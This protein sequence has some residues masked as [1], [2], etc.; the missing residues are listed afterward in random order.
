MS[1]FVQST[2]LQVTNLYYY[3]CVLFGFKCY[4]VGTAYFIQCTVCCVV[5]SGGIQHAMCR[6]VWLCNSG[7]TCA[8]NRPVPSVHLE[9]YVLKGRPGCVA[10]LY[11]IV[12]FIYL[13]TYTDIRHTERALLATNSG[14][15][16]LQE[17]NF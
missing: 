6:N 2:L 12:S 15:C 16:N 13:T 9:V 7:A 5:F 10:M 1:N 4:V 3:S 14:V 11:V 8:I 17:Q